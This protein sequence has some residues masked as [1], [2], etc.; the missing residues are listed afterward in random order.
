L[1]PASDEV[2]VLTNPSFHHLGFR[3]AAEGTFH[4]VRTLGL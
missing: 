1:A 3:M 2:P 4:M